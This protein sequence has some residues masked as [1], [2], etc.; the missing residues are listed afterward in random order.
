MKRLRTGLI[1]FGILLIL[2]ILA[3]ALGPAKLEKGMNKV[4]PHAPYQ[5]SDRA[6]ELHKTLVIGDWHSDSTLWKR[7][8]LSRSDRGHVDVPRM[9]EGNQAVQMF[10]SVTKS[11]SGQNYDKNS[12]DARDNITALVMLQ[13]W[14]PSTWTSLTM[15]AIY[16][17][18]KLHAM[19]LEAP[20]E[21]ALILTAKDLESLLARRAAGEHIVGGLLGTEGSHALDGELDNIDKLY[22]FGFR[23]MSLQHFFDNKLG[24]SLHGESGEGLTEFG[25]QAVDRMQALGIMID[26][27]HS[28]PQVV[29]DVLARSKA[30]LIVSHTGFYGYCQSPRNISDE[31]MQKIAQGGGII[32]VGYWDGAVC[33]ATPSGIVAAIRYG[34]DL[35]GEDRVALGSD[36]DGSIAAPFDSSE[37]RVLTHEMLKADFTETEI[38]KVMGGNMMRYL[39]ENLPDESKGMIH[40]KVN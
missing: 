30:P 14:P 21:F 32:A 3:L 1:I 5:I 23:M 22:H 37:L 34:I 33:D 9:R 38:R 24:G 36:Y 26:V 8:L 29:E 2:V 19:A 16:Q 28:A 17:A 6:R 40:G 7:D 20:N 25:R 39:A 4:L 35:V 27:S 10:T 15:R 18:D 13:A 31:L 11:P 12:S